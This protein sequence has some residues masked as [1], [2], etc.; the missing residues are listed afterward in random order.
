MEITAKRARVSIDE[1]GGQDHEKKKII[2]SARNIA[3]N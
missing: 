2:C 1:D 3:H